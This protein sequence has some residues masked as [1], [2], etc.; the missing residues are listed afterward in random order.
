MTI[1]DYIC[2]KIAPVRDIILGDR[3]IQIR[4]RAKVSNRLNRPLEYNE[5]SYLKRMLPEIENGLKWYHVKEKTERE[6]M[7][8]Q[9]ITTNLKISIDMQKKLQQYGTK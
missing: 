6:A 5:Q 8:A 3:R 2:S 1:I 4:L 9:N 7:P